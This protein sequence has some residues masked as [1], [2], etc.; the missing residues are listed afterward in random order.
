MFYAFFFN[1]VLGLGKY[2][3]IL[4]IEKKVGYVCCHSLVITS[5]IPHPR[6][7]IKCTN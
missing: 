1:E 2:Y 5:Q 3:G 6:Q 4:N 7:K